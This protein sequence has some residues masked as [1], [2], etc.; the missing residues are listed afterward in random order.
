MAYVSDETGRNE[1]Y[2]RPF[3]SRSRKWPIST[4]GGTQVRWKRDGR[5]LF[6]NEGGTL[7]TVPVNLGAE[8]NP[9]SST[10]LFSHVA[11]QGLSTEPNYD[12]ALDG[13]RVLV[14][15]R[16]GSKERKVHVVQSWFAEFQD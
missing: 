3:L 2:V 4:H 9:G 1:V 5:E 14:P 13:E 11:F 6:Y 8:F 15:D 7:M 12:I 16:L 10:P